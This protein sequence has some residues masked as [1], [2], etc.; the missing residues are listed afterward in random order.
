MSWRDLIPVHPAARKFELLTGRDRDDFDEDIFRRGIIEPVALWVSPAEELFILDGQNRL[1]AIERRI[2]EITLDD[3]G[4]LYVTP[5]EAM[6]KR[7]YSPKS[8]WIIDGSE[9]TI[10]L[11]RRL[12]PPDDNPEELVASLNVHRRHLTSEQKRGAIEAL[13]RGNPDRSDRQIAKT[14]KVSPTTVGAVRAKLEQTGE[15]SKLD[16]RI[17]SDGIA[18]PATKP[19]PPVALLN[20]ADKSKVR[21]AMP[22]TLIQVSTLL[23]LDPARTIEEL[24]RCLKDARRDIAA[25][26]IEKRVAAGRGVLAALSVNVTDLR[27]AG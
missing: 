12:F 15:V 7:R 3:D 6:R 22:T 26:P 1:D 18:Q 17:G 4:Y 27:P 10:E 20:S 23:R 19:A 2:G 21:Q 11:P 16:T 9:E 24:V 14:V 5:S 25:M 8:P 13:L